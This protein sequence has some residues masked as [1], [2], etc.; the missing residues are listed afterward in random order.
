MKRLFLSI[1]CSYIF[2]TSLSFSQQQKE[3]VD[4]SAIAKIKDEGMNRS[5]AMDILGN[6]T[7]VYGPR[8]TGSPQF[9]K[10]AEWAR[11]KLTDWGIENSHLE[12]WGPFGRGWTLKR[13]SAHITEPKIFPIIAY[14]KAWSPSTKGTISAELI[15]LDAKVDSTFESYRKKVKG[16]IVLLSDSRT[17]KPHWEAEASRVADS[18]LLKMANADMPQARQRQF[19][20]SPEQKARAMTN[21][22]KWMM[23]QEEGALAVFE[24]NRGDGGT[25]FVQGATVPNHPDTPSTRSIRSFSSKAPKILPQIVVGAEHY[26]SLIR[27][28]RKGEKVKVEMNLEVEFTKED[29]G[30]NIIAEI[31]GTDLKDEIVMLGAHFDS[32]HGG[33]GAT[34]NATGSTACME[35]LRILKTTGLQPRRT[36]RIGLWGGEEQGLLG[37]REYVKKHFGVKDDSTQVITYKPEGEKFSVYFNNDNGTG[38]IR[39]VYMQGNDASRPVFRSWLKPFYDMGATTLTLS[40]TGSTDHASFDA[41]GLPG[42]QFI[43]DEIEYFT[44]TWHSTMDVYDRVQEEDLKQ[45]AII[46][47][48]FAYNAAMRDAQFP[49]KPLP[50]PRTGQGNN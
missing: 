10:A 46:M 29:S 42:F 5:Q 25:I 7:D 22:K 31:P 3:S 32:W 11:T 18:S 44:R 38:K 21:Y 13:F 33:T 37:S 43:Q 50:Q 30:Y 20:D 47:A 2:I 12:S 17:V 41:I 34:D 1:L 40:N 39:G 49:R 15:F 14:P 6:L 9:K 48:S 16:K 8:L 19:Q 35:A 24:T 36:I 27:L 23:L 4:T 28:L 26:N 45:A